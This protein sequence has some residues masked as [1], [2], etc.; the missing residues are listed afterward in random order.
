MILL[1]YPS[2]RD[3]AVDLRHGVDHPL[4][5]Q[6]IAQQRSFA[7][8]N[9]ARGEPTVRGLL[10]AAENVALY[11]IETHRDAVDG[12]AT[13]LDAEDTLALATIIG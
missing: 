1:V 7:D 10:R 2:L 6:Q 5:G 12:L 8:E 11:L 9:A 13:T 4:V 3:K